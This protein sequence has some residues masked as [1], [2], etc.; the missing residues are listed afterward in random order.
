M[1]DQST[2]APGRGV[3]VDVW[4]PALWTFL[5]SVAYAPSESTP[6]RDEAIRKLTESLRVLLPC[7]TCRRHFNTYCDDVG[8]PS[9]DSMEKWTVD[10]HNRVNL[11]SGKPGMS[12]EAA[13]DHWVGGSRSG[14]GCGHA[15]RDGARRGWAIA[16]IVAFVVLMLFFV[17]FAAY[18]GAK[19]IRGSGYGGAT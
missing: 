7:P 2:G 18:R 13:R 8:L 10:L 17:V 11:Q 14:C 19:C 1:P 6:E 3:P 5:H 9:C 16:G 12:Y 4:G 15:G